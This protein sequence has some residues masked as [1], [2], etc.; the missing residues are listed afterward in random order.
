MATIKMCQENSCRKNVAEGFK[1]QKIGLIKAY[2]K[3]REKPYFKPIWT[4]TI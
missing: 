2:K 4:G 3:K 1:A